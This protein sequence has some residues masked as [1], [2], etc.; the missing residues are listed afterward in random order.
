[1]E[2]HE[3][4]ATQGDACRKEKASHTTLSHTTLSTTPARSTRGWDG[5]TMLDP[6]RMNQRGR[7]TGNTSPLR[8]QPAL[9]AQAH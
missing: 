7:D 5:M 2:G 6:V 8:A 1:M 3:N 9:Q 4:G